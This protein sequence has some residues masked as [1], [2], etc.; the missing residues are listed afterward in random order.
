M[1]LSDT[2]LH[3]FARNGLVEPYEPKNIQG[4]SIDLTLGDTIKVETPKGFEKVFEE[5]QIKDRTYLLKPGQFAL[6]CTAEKIKVPNNHCAS[7]L[8][9]STAARA[10]FEQL[11]WLVRSGLPRC[12]CFGATQ[13]PAKSLP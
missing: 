4:C 3:E 2:T 11:Q 10:G 13:Q 12:P 9:R 6:A 8:L 7:L 1:I 5:I